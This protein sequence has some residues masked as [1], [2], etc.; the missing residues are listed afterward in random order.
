MVYNPETDCLKR[1]LNSQEAIARGTVLAALLTRQMGQQPLDP[2]LETETEGSRS[3]Q[4]IAKYQQEE[5]QLK[6]NDELFFKKGKLRHEFNTICNDMIQKFA[7]KLKPQDKDY[8][9]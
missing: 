4:E 3:E 5:R 2:R 8:F 6:D 1:T 9:E 7:G